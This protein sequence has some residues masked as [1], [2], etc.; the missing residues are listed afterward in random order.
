MVLAFVLDHGSITP[1]ECRELLGLGESQSAR[2][3]VSRYLKHWTE[4]GGFLRR[5]GKS[6]KVCYFSRSSARRE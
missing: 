3:E 2:V 1:R 5:E 6:P 4:E